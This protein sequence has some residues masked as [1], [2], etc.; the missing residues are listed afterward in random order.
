MF[1][2][3]TRKAGME[4][5]SGRGLGVVAVDVNGDGWPDLFVARDASPNLL[6]INQHD[7]AFRDKGLEDDIVYNPVGIARSGMGVDAGDI[8]GDG[9]PDFVVTNFDHEYHALYLSNAS[10]PYGEATV[11]S[12]LARYTLPYVGWGVKFLD[13]D[14]DGDQDLMIANGHIHE[15]INLS[16]R[17]VHYRE[18]ILLLEN[19]GNGRFQRVN[20]PNIPAFTS[21][22]VGRGLATG[23]FNNDG[24]IDA[25]VMN[26]NHHPVLLQNSAGN[27]NAWIG[28]KLIGTRSNRD[29]IGARL[30]L[31]SAR[32]TLTRWITGGSS[33]L[34][35]SD[36][37]VI[38]G[39]GSAHESGTLEILWPSQVRQRLSNLKLNTYT[40]IRERE[41]D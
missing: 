23:D 10:G 13:F 19:N 18:P 4:D 36:K 22:I 26:L 34:S 14:N 2:D 9:L 20:I 21:G 31:Q 11:T 7:G 39:L 15:Q 8:N 12:N 37:R 16:N 41:A 24:F 1:S 29:A 27:G 33:F 38:F 32:G 35:S 5:L 17:E 30:T 6:L 25:I 28:V 40:T 3:V